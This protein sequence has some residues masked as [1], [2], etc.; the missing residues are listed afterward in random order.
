MA[1]AEV[2]Q[3]RKAEAGRAVAEAPVGL[4]RRAQL[5]VG[6]L[7]NFAYDALRFWR[8]SYLLGA[9]TWPRASWPTPISWNTGWR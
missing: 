6:L 9:G 2:S 5:S 4:I 3:R 7:R 1:V 8:H